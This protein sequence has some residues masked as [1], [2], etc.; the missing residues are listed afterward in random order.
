MAKKGRCTICG[1]P[2]R[3]TRDHVPPRGS[4]GTRDVDVRTLADHLGDDPDRQ[5]TLRGGFNV[6]SICATCNNVRLGQ[7]YDPE[8]KSF[9]ESVALWIRSRFREGLILPRMATFRSRP[10]RLAKAVVGHLLAA[11]QRTRRF[12]APR[13]APMIKVMRDFFLNYDGGLP[14][15]LEI[16]AWPYPSD[17]IVVCRGV[18]VVRPGHT[19]VCD[20][21]KFFPLAYL[22][23]FDR[24]EGFTMDLPR[25]SIPSHLGPRDEAEVAIDFGV[26]CRADWPEQPGPN[27]AILFNDAMTIVARPRRFDA[28]PNQALQA[29]PKSTPR[30]GA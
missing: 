30:L 8:L 6:P 25:L 7:Q 14:A 12:I 22:V 26:R 13:T 24:P 20:T 10:V 11:E 5:R 18:G 9:T 2:G 27:D 4:A 21:L 3:L 28:G 23:A 29:T 19:L 16:F 17:L 1:N 15:T